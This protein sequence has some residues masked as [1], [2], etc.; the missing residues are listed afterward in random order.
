MLYG[1]VLRPPSYGATLVS[2]DL[3]PAKSLKGVSVVREGQLVGVAAP[4]TFAAEQALT[5]VAKTAKWE[6]A[7]HPSSTELFDYL[8]Q[9]AQGGVPANPFSDEVAQAHKSLRQSYHV[10]YAQHARW[11][12]ASRW[13]NGPTA[14]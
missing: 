14:N 12:H 13:R 3:E 4:T 7:S 6:S 11:K 2:I 5:A 9:H 10:A 8:R 1:K